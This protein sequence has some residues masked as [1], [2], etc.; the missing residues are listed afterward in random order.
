MGTVFTIDVRDPGDW[1]DGIADVVAW[2]HQVD[3][4]FSTYRADSDLSRLT[5][6]EV[7]LAD[8][9][10][11]VAVVLDLCA[12]MQQRTGGAFTAL[13]GGRLDP[14]GLVKGWAIERASE[15]LRAHGSANHAVNG[16]GDMQLAGFAAPERPWSV[17][18]VDPSDRARI[19][20]VVRGHDL[21]VATSGT[22]ERGLHVVDPFTGVPVADVASA[23][24]AGP[25]LT[26]ADC[27]ATA[28]MVLGRAA[29]RWIDR[30]DG[31]EALVVRADGQQLISNGW[32]ELAG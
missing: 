27:F 6:G 32:R 15:M 25:S 16:G 13:A 21:A 1:G 5:R 2:L 3:A 22:A 30:V 9:H 14:T 19:L 7:R 4:V 18:I 28:A 11:D 29:P 31:Y 8:T 23:T 10:P 20:T 24:V 26:Y 17:G 12:E